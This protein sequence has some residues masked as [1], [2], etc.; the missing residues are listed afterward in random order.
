MAATNTITQP[1]AI[2]PVETGLHDVAAQFAHT[3]PG[4]GIQVLELKTQ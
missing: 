4:F 1:T 3:V 2:V